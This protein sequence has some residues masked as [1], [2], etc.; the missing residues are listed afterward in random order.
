MPTAQLPT[1]R[2]VLVVVAHPDDES[3][4]P[5]GTLARYAH[6]GEVHLLCGTRGE[7]GVVDA[8]LLEG[9]S[10]IAELRTAELACAAG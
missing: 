1:W 8:H 10:D 5:G 7:V 3:F 2:H 9:Y 6:D 4:G